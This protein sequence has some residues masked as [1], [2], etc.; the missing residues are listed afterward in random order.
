VPHKIELFSGNCPL[1]R[2]VED[3]LLV[4]KCAGCNLQ[5]YDLSKDYERVLPKLNQY[6]VKAVPTVVI[7]GRIKIEGLPE[8]T[9]ICSE[10]LYSWLEREF[11]FR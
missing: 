6:R 10:E 9:F 2:K 7:D 5:I 4:G 8:F 3:M 11:S 1:C